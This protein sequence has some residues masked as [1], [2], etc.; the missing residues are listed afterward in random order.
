MTTITKLKFDS[1]FDLCFLTY[2]MTDF[3]SWFAK[4]CFAAYGDDFELIKAGGS[5][6][7]KK[8]DGRRISTETIFQCYAPESP[9]TFAKNA[10]KKIEDS[11]PAVT[12]FWPNMK[13]WVFVH[14]NDNGITPAVSDKLEELRAAYPQIKI[15]QRSRDLL[16][17]L[18]NELSLTD[19]RDIYPKSDVDIEGVQMEHVRPLLRRIISDCGDLLNS[20]FFGEIPD[21]AKIDHNGLSPATKFELRRA[22]PHVGVVDRYLDG[23]SNPANATKVQIS[24]RQKYL[25]LKDLAY[26][27]DEI[28]GALVDYVRDTNAPVSTASATVIVAYFFEA[29]DVFENVDPPKC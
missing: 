28:F 16:K 26:K 14:N 12:S 11:F 25:D 13:E 15:R 4:L 8:S 1:F 10:V 9:V 27:P 20:D 22:M 23:L 2:K 21:E 17:E 19:L 18:H 7:D 5:S 24:L 6:G 29:C 3:E